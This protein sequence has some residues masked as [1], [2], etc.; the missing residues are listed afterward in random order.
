MGPED[1]VAEMM[2][3]FLAQRELAKRLTKRP[4]GPMI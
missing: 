3:D 2:Q 4:G 1:E